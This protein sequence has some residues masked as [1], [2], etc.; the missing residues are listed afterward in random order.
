MRCC[1]AVSALVMLG[2]TLV[3]QPLDAGDKTP[4]K[5]SQTWR[6]KIAEKEAAKLAPTAGFLT[7]QKAFE[8]LWEGW[9]LKDKAPTI[10]FEKEI[11]IVTV[12]S[13]GPNVPNTTFT[14]TKGDLKVAAI[15]TLI[16]GPGFGY[17]IDVV[18]RDGIKTIQGKAISEEKK[19]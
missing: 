13:G 7:T 1:F 9:K 8:E 11:V 3:L 5:A 4:V 18:P 2:F 16:A 19:K 10:N 14:L 12:S 6:G 15:Q 17:S